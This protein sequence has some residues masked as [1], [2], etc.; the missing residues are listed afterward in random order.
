MIDYQNVID[1]IHTNLK[2]EVNRGLVA[3][4]IPE[5]ANIDVQNFG[6]H[7]RLINGET[8]AT[9]DWNKKFSI[10]SIS[11]VLTLAMALPMYPKNLWKR[12]DVEPS[13][14]PFNHLSLLELENGIPRNPLIN[15]GALVIA[16]ILVT[17]LDNPKEDFLNYVRFVVDDPTIVFN[18]NVANSE[19]MTGYNNYAAANLLKAYGNLKNDVDDVLDFY[20]HQ[21]AIE[22]TCEQLSKAFFM[23]ANHGACCLQKVVL[24]EA[25]LH[26]YPIIL[27]FQYGLP[28]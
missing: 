6:I 20:F 9:G 26:Y 25:L 11:K 16:D 14:N 5:L 24:A 18:E 22:L 23:F 17:L 1:T 19:R 28:V 3:S 15:A 2:D 21:C 10:Q 8:F 13:G 12:V 27:Q 7:L 4:Y